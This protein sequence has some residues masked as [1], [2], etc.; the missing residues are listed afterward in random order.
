MDVLIRYHRMRG[1]NTLWQVGTDHAGIA[2][3]IVVEQQLKAQGKTRHDL[4]REQFVE[5]VWAWKEESGSRSRNQM[6]RLGASADWSR[7]RFTMDD[8]PV[9]RGARDVRAAVRRRAHLSRQAP[10]QLGPE[11]RH[12][13]VRPR[14]RERGG[15][16]KDLGDPLSA[17]RR[18]RCASSSPRRGPRR[19]WATS[20]VAVNPDDERYRASGRQGGRAAAHRPHDSDHRRRLRRPRVRHRRR[21]DHAGARLQRLGRRRSATGCRRCRSSTSTRRSTTTRRRS[22]AA[23]TATSRA[24]RC[25]RT[26]Q[27]AGLVVSEKAHTMIVPRCGRTGE[28]VEPMLTDQW[29]V[30]MTQAR[31][32]DASVLPGQVDPGPVP[33]GGRASGLAA[34]RARRGREASRSCPREWL[35]T[36]LHWINNIQDWCISRQLWWGHQIPAWYDEAGNVYVARSEADARAQ[37]RAK[38]GREPHVVRARRRRARHLVQLGAVVPF[39]ARLAGGDAGA[40]ARSCRRRCWSPASTS[41]SSGS[42]A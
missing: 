20:A 3:Q 22:I 17:R 26:S 35:S 1:D 33:R 18:Q 5:R 40:R 25:W 36:Y 16:G 23:S 39:H 2:T 8:G 19:C 6:R 30:A 14:S 15:A 41:S 13:G 28:V 21:Q 10:R 37:A 12:G 31:A 7:E 29:F 34:G 27:R 11:A 38:L 32:G 4:G 42:R 9:G 24:R